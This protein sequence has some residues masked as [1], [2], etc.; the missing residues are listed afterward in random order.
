M[1]KLP[2]DMER[3]TVEAPVEMESSDQYEFSPESDVI[4]DAVR[5]DGDCVCV[6]VCFRHEVT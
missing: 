1:K 3:E 2:E 6:C 5:L 4:R